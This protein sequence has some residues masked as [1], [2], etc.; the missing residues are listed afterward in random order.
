[1]KLSSN[2]RGAA[3]MAIAMVSFAT[4]DAITKL[5]AESISVA[6]V[7]LVRG[8]FA[9]VI[10]ALIG[11][12]RGAFSQMSMIR[13]PLVALRAAGEVAATVTFLLALAHLPIAN[14]SAILQALPLAVTMGAALAFGQSV[15]WRRWLAICAG[16]TGVIITVRPGYEGFSVYSL[17]ALASVGFCT[18]RDLATS[19]LPSDIPTHLVS[20]ITSIS[21][22]VTGAILL[23]PMGGWSSMEVSGV[24]LLALSATLLLLGYNFI[25]M[26]MRIGEV[27]FIAP[28]R[29]TSLLCSI[30][31][32]MILFSE[33]PDLPMIFG[34]TI[35]VASGLYTLYRERSVGRYKTAAESAG[36]SMGPDGI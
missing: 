1:M 27:S 7:M 13:Q 22:T 12:Q 34:A 5:M 3:Y 19:R 6:Q 11:W 25:I 32:G 35:I 21:V 16:F 2:M 23:K 36:P 24:A 26:A 30:L 18:V 31:F 9:S 14:V 15:G 20:T 17:F 33:F 8:L 28:F 29:Y 4:N 10:I